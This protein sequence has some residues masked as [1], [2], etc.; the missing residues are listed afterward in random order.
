MFG[1]KL[2]GPLH[3]AFPFFRRAGTPALI[4][5]PDSAVGRRIGADIPIGH[6]SLV[7]LMHPIMR[8]WSAIEFIKWDPKVADVLGEGLRA[9]RAQNAVAL[10]EAV[11]ARF[12]KV[13]R[14][15]RV[16]AEIDDPTRA[17]TPD[18]G[19]QEGDILREVGQQEY[20]AMFNAVPWTWRA[21]AQQAAETG[22][23]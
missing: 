5:F 15:V 7:Y 12:A 8:F 17:P 11:N 2:V 9:A 10:M 20:E 14:C 13:W 23:A 6:K 1:V 16:L 22:G 3:R 4:N 21:D 19:F 18:F